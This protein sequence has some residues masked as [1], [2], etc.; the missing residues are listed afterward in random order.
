MI[1]GANVR[2]V[3]WR[4]TV[5]SREQILAALRANAAPFGN[6]PPRPAHY[7]PVTQVDSLELFERFKAE[8]ER[9]TGK[10]YRVPDSESAL[11]QVKAILGDDSAVLTWGVLPIP[12]L[13]NFLDEQHVQRIVPPLTSGDAVAR[14]AAMQS[15]A[16]VRV[17]I[18]G[19]DA[20]LATTGTLVLAANTAQARL[21]SLLPLVHIALIPLERIF[22]NM[23]AWIAAGGRD[24]LASSSAITFITGPSRTSDIEMQT[25]LGVHGPQE[26]HVII[27]PSHAG[28]K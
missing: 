4:Q 15:L 14:K 11:Q 12:E 8:L 23:E 22:A 13:A 21:V 9:L 2:H 18:T 7:L 10:V 16:A 28:S 5:S 6:A 25:I 27:Y 20:G 17:G 24:R 26:V 3:R 19:A 1:C